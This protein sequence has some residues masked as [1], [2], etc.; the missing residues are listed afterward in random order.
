M[1]TKAFDLMFIGHAAL[2]GTTTMAAEV[3]N[4][5]EQEKY[6]PGRRD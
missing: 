6:L 2:F 3:G 4:N 5:T 1:Q